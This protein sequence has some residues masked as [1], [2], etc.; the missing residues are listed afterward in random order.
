VRVQ[1][2][3]NEE[4]GRRG[5]GMDRTSC[6]VGS[7]AEIRGDLGSWGYPAPSNRTELNFI[8]YFYFMRCIDLIN[9]NALIM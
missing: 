1:S 6:Q 4:E 8:I 3:E 2:A 9:C 5:G 7:R